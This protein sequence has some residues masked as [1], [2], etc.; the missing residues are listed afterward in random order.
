MRMTKLLI[1]MVAL[2]CCAQ[3]VWA[4]GPAI[5][6]D[7]EV[8]DLGFVS[9]G[10]SVSV[11]FPFTNGGDGVLVLQGIGA[12][13]GC[14]ETYGGSQEVPPHGRSEVVA[15][16]DTGRLNPGKNQKHIHVRCNDASRYQVTLTMVI[17]V[18]P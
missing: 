4:V 9:R 10:Q 16:L 15:V 17:E 12:D 11:R 1:V 13:C 14:T 8:Q 5:A 2:F 7:Y 3:P 18:I 6:F